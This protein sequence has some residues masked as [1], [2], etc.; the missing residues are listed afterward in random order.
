MSSTLSFG[1]EAGLAP[2]N[3]APGAG[4]GQP[5]Q[6]AFAD[7]LAFKLR[8]RGEEVEHKPALGR[9]GVDGI[10]QGNQADVPALQLGH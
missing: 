2:A 5:G 9:M 10:G 8:E 4:G 1:R 3:A 6:R 7:K